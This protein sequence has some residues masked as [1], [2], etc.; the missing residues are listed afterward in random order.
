MED[1]KKLQ[2]FAEDLERSLLLRTYPIG[3]RLLKSEEEIPENSFRPK[4]DKKE[5]FALCQ[6]FGLARREGIRIA[7]FK[8]DHWCFEPLI[9]FGLVEPP[10]AYMEGLTSY[11]FFIKDKKKA[12]M[13]AKRIPKLSFGEY[14][15]ICIAPLKYIN[16]EPHLILIYCKPAQLRHLLLSLRYRKGYIVKSSFDP[17]GSCTNAIIPSFL[18]KECYI[19]LPDPGDYERAVA[20]E[21][22]LILSIPK[23][24]L[25]ELISGFLYFEESGRGYR[26]FS[27]MMR[28]DFPQPPFYREFFRLWGLD[29]PKENL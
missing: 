27:Y 17:I 20:G 15:G 26:K 2:E 25:D 23:E 6:A 4:K 3:I 29:E 22:E 16:F 13:R 14:K 21:E 19:T 11:P 8:E 5:H 24:R 18:T 10:K 9:T 7:M 28:P 1:L 12:K